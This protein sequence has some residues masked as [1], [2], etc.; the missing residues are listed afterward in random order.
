M[1][2]L[3]EPEFIA[4]EKAIGQNIFAQISRG[5]SMRLYV[6]ESCVFLSIPKH[7][8]K[9]DAISFLRSQMVWLRKH[10]LKQS[11]GLE[12]GFEAFQLRGD[13][14]DRVPI[15]GHQHN[16]EL[17]K[18]GAPFVHSEGKLCLLAADLAGAKRQLINA[19]GAIHL[20]ALQHDVKLVSEI[21]QV[22]PRRVTVKPMRTLWGSLQP[23]NAMSVNFAL[24][25]AP[26]EC[27]HYIIAHELAHVLE[28]N[29][30][31]RFWAQVKRAF[32]NYE[33][34]HD[35]LRVHHSFLMGL[36]ERV[37]ALTL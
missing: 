9:G 37:F 8:S 17:S 34:V 11:V 23:S 33:A 12:R 22:N 21:L 25:F 14:N 28:R 35:Y 16:I 20:R 29:H 32:P 10:L 19:L 2:I 26:R 4:I 3:D 24:I 36:Q 7:V 30:S 6:R 1:I 18:G 13:P 5:R 15:F 31:A 27:T